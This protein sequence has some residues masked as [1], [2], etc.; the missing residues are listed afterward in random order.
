MEQILTSAKGGFIKITSPTYTITG[1]K[2]T[3]LYIVSTANLSVCNITFENTVDNERIFVF[4]CI[5]PTVF[6]FP[7][8][9]G[10]LSASTTTYAVGENYQVVL[11]MT[12]ILSSTNSSKTLGILGFIAAP[13]LSPASMITGYTIQNTFPINVVG[14]S[15]GYYAGISF[16]KINKITTLKSTLTLE[17]SVL[18][19]TVPAIFRI[20]VFP[21]TG[22]NPSGL[23]IPTLT[24]VN[25]FWPTQGFTFATTASTGAATSYLAFD[26]NPA[27]QWLA[28]TGTAESLKIT[29]DLA[30]KISGFILA[31]MV[32]STRL[33]TSWSILGSNGVPG[34]YTTLYSSTTP[35]TTE[36]TY[37]ISNASQGFG[38]SGMYKEYS[39]VGTTSSGTTGSN[40]LTKFQLIQDNPVDVIFSSDGMIGSSGIYRV[41]TLIIRCN[42]NSLS[43]SLSTFCQQLSTGGTHSNARWFIKSIT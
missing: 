24:S 14:T 2:S 37:V 43:A 4:R 27:T 15:S 33:W 42:I 35:I 21:N 12:Q 11:T 36:T 30:F 39:F 31:P 28:T 9:V 3:N 38:D 18:S 13:I 25:Y 6:N 34:V 7:Q 23:L 1:S 22:D 19:T 41:A 17:G 20:N 8:P 5:S 29:S 10:T 32:G 16:D 26:N 40:G